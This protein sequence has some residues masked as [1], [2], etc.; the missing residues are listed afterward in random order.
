[1][2]VV[3]IVPPEANYVRAYATNEYLG[4]GYLASYLRLHGYATE[5]FNCNC[6]LAPSTDDVVARVIESGPAVVGLTIPTMPN[7]PGAI[8]IIRKLKEAGYG[9]HVTVGGHVP[10]FE[11]RQLLSMEPRL[12]SVVRGEGEETLLELVRTV[13]EGRPYESIR[14]LACRIADQVVCRSQRPLIANLDTLPFPERAFN[15]MPEKQS[16]GVAEV[17]SSRGC[18]GL[19]T[20]CSVFSFYSTSPGPRFRYRSP[21]NVVLEALELVGRGARS[22]L[23]VDDNFV[24]SGKAGKH[25]AVQI[26]TLL[27]EAAPT[28]TF[29]ITCRAN[30]VDAGTFRELKQ[31]GLIRVFLGI[32]SGVDSALTRYRKHVSVAQNLQA[33]AVLNGLGLKWDMGFMIYDPDTTFDEFEANVRFLRR[34]RLYYFNAAPLLLNGMIVFPG[35]PIEQRLSAEGRLERDPDAALRFAVVYGDYDSA[36][37]FMNY[38]YMLR[39]ADAERMRGLVDHAYH[40]LAALFDVMWPLVSEY[41]RWFQRAAAES[42]SDAETL[43]RAVGAQLVEY[44]TLLHWLVGLGPLV[45]NLLEDMLALVRK[46]ATDGE[47]DAVFEERVSNYLKKGSADPFSTVVQRAEAFLRRTTVVGTRDG[48]DISLSGPASRLPHGRRQQDSLGP[49]IA[50]PQDSEVP[51]R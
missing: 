17:A 48:R 45:M 24:G 26:A 25:R 33:I 36:L 41:E 5:L 13:L 14:G 9:G 28:V 38:S 11:Y 23:F 31:F 30:D 46:R 4:V 37:H 15:N 42:G 18:Y 2:D 12:D 44:R 7:L 29:N 51:T 34:N 16:G 27:H 50:L 21:E 19:C 6:P 22:I 40:N 32:E 20:F 35:T 47:C 49:G 1:M 39:D 43:Q 8:H 3:L 10:T